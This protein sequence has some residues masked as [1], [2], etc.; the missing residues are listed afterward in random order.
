MG[1]KI[2]VSVFD[3]EPAAFEGLEAL[4]EL[5]KSHDIT[6]YATSVIVKDRSGVVAVRQTAEKGPLGTLLGAVTGGLV[7]LLGGPAGAAV[8]AYIGG[9]GGM[10]Y[11]LFK[12]GVGIDFVDEV[13]ALLT[14][15]KAAVIADI[16]ETW[17]A[18]VNTR[19][20]ALGGTTFRR[21]P[22]EVIDEQM[23]R[24]SAATEQELA[25]MKAELKESSDETRAKLKASF[26]AQKRKLEATSVQIQNRIDE[27]DAEMDARLA[28]LHKQ[29]AE[30][31]DRH[32]ARIDA[33]IKELEAAQAARKAKLTEA[34]QL[35][36]QSVEAMSE[37]LVS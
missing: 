19:L 20:G 23:V 5:H 25:E 9:F 13:G 34:R 18:P 7:G 12:A 17:V 33:R 22:G 16:D 27:T 35:A 10:T 2:L 21:L 3:T 29:Q 24:E 32:R 36:E 6:V 15:G 14:P 37:A 8:G 30:A 28:T 26:D 31:H 4:K 1:N 11:D